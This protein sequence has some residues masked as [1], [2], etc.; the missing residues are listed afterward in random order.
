MAIK[1]DDIVFLSEEQVRNLFD[2]HAALESQRRA[3]RS[4]GAGSALQPD[5]ILM[6]RNGQQSVF[7][8]TAAL[9]SEGA[10]CKFGSVV[11]ENTQKGIPTVSA[12]I[13]V[14]HPDT[15]Q[16]RAILDGT[17]IT[18]LR[19]AAASAVAVEAL[20][21]P[22]SSIVTIIGSG[23]QAEAH[24]RT[25]R[26]VLNL[27]EVRIF[28]DNY[29]SSSS[30]AHHLSNQISP[31]V[32]AYRD[33]SDAIQGAQVIVTATTSTD[34]VIQA[35]DVDEGATVVSIGSYAKNK[36]EIPQDFIEAVDHVVVDHRDIAL[37]HAGPVIQAV[38]DGVL[39]IEDIL[40]LG[41]V[42]IGKHPGRASS[43]DR[44]YFNSV[45]IGSQDAAAANLVLEKLDS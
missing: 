12:T 27:E 28:S 34:P 40:T 37:K 29:D 9:D 33:Y 10:V 19:T 32:T 44:I 31:T 6:E 43:K 13:L 8:Y 5:R 18:T 11:P 2:E 22:E 25:L 42:L 1:Q 38:E 26:H 24:A 30:L 21:N 4:L 15:G 17:H 45:G 23:V 35:S 39:P 14:L 41:E 20:A 7:C 3:F 16:V 36:H